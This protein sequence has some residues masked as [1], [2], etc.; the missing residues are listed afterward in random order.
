MLTSEI[1][2]MAAQTNQP[3]IPC[4]PDRNHPDIH[5]APFDATKVPL[6][7][8]NLIEASAGTGKTYSIAVLTLRLLMEMQYSIKEILMVTFTKA[9]VAELEQRVRLFVRQA[10]L[11]SQG[12]CIEDETITGIVEHYIGESSAVEMQEVLSSALTFL[13]E[14]SVM[15]IH[16][17][18]QGVLQEFAFETKQAF[19]TELLADDSLLLTEGVN[20]FWRAHIATMPFN[21]LALVHDG[22]LKKGILEVIKNQQAG[23]PFY[24]YQAKLDYNLDAGYYATAEKALRTLQIDMEREKDRLFFYVEAHWQEMLTAV[25]G[26]RYAPA[27]FKKVMNDPRSFMKLILDNPKKP[28]YIRTLFKDLL[29]DA[30]TYFELQE[31]VTSLKQALQDY[32]YC[33]A[34]QQIGGYLNREKEKHNQLSFDDL[35]DQLHRS[36]LAPGHERLVRALRQKYKAVFIDEFQDTDQLQYE[37]FQKA[38]G[39]ETTLF[40]IGDP[41]QSIYAFRRADI[42]T[43][44]K[45]SKEVDHGYGMNINFRSSDPYIQGMNAF[46]LPEPDFDTFSFA[47]QPEPAFGYIPVKS[48]PVNTKGQLWLD[49]EPEV[50]IEILTGTEKQHAQM[51]LIAQVA[52]LLDNDSYTIRKPAEPASGK[53]PEGEEAP[54]GRGRQVV[55]SDIGVLVNSNDDATFYKAELGKKGIPAIVL[56][57]DK[58]LASPEAA[59]VQ[60]LL[61]AMLDLSRATI[62]RAL[63]SPLTGLQPADVLALN[64]A[65]TI[66]RFKKYKLYWEKDGIYRALFSFVHDFE[67]LSYLLSDDAAGGERIITN[68]YQIIE[69]LYKNQ[70]LKNY[71]PLEVVDWLKRGMESGDGLGDEYIQRIDSDS[72]SVTIMTIHKSKGLQFNIVLSSSLDM[73]TGLGK[74]SVIEAFKN[75][76]HAY[77]SIP[78]DQ[79]SKDLEQLYDAQSEQENRRKLYVAITRAVYKCYIFR[80]VKPTAKKRTPEPQKTLTPFIT[81]FK[82]RPNPLI[83]FKEIQRLPSGYRHHPRTD[84][85]QAGA[86]LTKPG[87]AVR[88]S[89][90]QKDWTRL[91]YT[92]L[93]AGPAIHIRKWAENSTPS[94]YDQFIFNDLARGNKTG[95][96][97]HYIFEH[98][99]FGNEDLW[100]SVIEEAIKRFAPQ[101]SALYQAPLL[102]LLR[103]LLHTEIQVGGPPFTLSSVHT[104]HRMHEFEFDFPVKPFHPAALQFLSQDN[105]QVQLVN[106]DQLEGLMNGKID[107]LFEQGGKFYIL[108]WKSTFLGNTWQQYQR[109][110]ME[111]AMNLHN[112][113]L[114]YYIYTVAVKKYLASRIPDFDYTRDF[115][116]VIY[117]F[118]R[119]VRRGKQTGFYTFTPPKSQ[120]DDLEAI[121]TGQAKMNAKAAKK[122]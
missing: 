75:S 104:D 66:D 83:Q 71:G 2:I 82:Q 6:E 11:V 48:P 100:T 5:L 62:N 31:S 102:D 96:M 12:V 90:V 86:A 109:E 25:K 85:H 111:E 34:I 94:D 57:D 46:F 80:F 65:Q 39:S 23:K 79:I 30:D 113:H 116:G 72:N 68:L 120:V 35:I 4:I 101:K 77:M 44:L 59:S 112:Y 36:L 56:G 95:N 119:G 13:D 29:D 19:G 89:L 10:A 53:S 33:A 74:N 9:A 58:I 91:S 114:Q 52:A 28:N 118:V 1:V 122:S 107:L 40:Y 115:G 16:S 73:T 49:H 67:V 21:L 70:T 50:P 81:A 93:A 99:Y 92:Y 121:L 117:V 14:M 45:A 41:K 24:V 18:C 69:L 22:N 60:Y 55:P 20:A 15:T 88:F 51:G 63:L 76:S 27:F 26:N 42:D 43:Y 97:L 17:F 54:K 106:R 108:D 78:K 103:E 3:D 61:E 32:I 84:P 47:E 37:I 87:S 7:G 8:S 64:D 98:I 38:F 105:K 110:G